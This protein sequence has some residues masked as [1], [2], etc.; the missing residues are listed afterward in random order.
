MQGAGLVSVSKRIKNKEEGKNFFFGCAKL[1][2]CYLKVSVC[3]CKNLA[4]YKDF[5]NLSV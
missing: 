5:A 1:S 4:R 2:F 3:T